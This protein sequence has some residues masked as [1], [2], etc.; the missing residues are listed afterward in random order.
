MKGLSNINIA[1]YIKQ[2]GDSQSK[3]KGAGGGR[4]QRMDKQGQKETLL[5]VMDILCITQ[6]MFY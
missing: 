4:R 6:M 5:R 2:Y 1:L 3:R